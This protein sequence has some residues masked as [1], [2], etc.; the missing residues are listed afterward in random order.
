MIE[1]LKKKGERKDRSFRENRKKGIIFE[2][3]QETSEFH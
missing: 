3:M 2:E 1:N